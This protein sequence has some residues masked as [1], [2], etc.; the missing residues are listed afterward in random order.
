MYQ[1]HQKIGEVGSDSLTAR[2]QEMLLFFELK[3]GKMS[4]KR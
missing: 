4:L 2:S 1:T 3:K